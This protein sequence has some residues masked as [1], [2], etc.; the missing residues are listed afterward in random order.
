LGKPKTLTLDNGTCVITAESAKA[1]APYYS[2][3]SF[4]FR[5]GDVDVALAVTVQGKKSEAQVKH[6]RYLVNVAPGTERVVALLPT[7]TVKDVAVDTTTV[8]GK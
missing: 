8:K 1:D 3:S 7:A 6:Y 2:G 5:S 4:K